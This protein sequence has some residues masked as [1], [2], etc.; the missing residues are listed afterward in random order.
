MLLK[1]T[2]VK[3]SVNGGVCQVRLAYLPTSTSGTR[4]PAHGHFG[5]EWFVCTWNHD[6]SV[7]TSPSRF[8]CCMSEVLLLLRDHPI[9]PPQERRRDPQAD[10]PQ[11][12]ES[13]L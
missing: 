7:K 8:L 10:G 4:V 12:G 1:S 13:G 3:R 2:R 9:R 6:Y 11:T 5:T